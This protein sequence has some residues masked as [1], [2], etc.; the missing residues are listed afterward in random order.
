M[1]DLLR[2]LVAC[3][4]IAAG[5][6]LV[7]YSVTERSRAA[8]SGRTRTGVRPDA[9]RLPAVRVGDARR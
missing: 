3:L 7:L 8:S 1:L 5:L 2:L 4:P 6:A 9:S